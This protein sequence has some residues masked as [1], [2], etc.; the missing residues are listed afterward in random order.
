MMLGGVNRIRL[1]ELIRKELRQMLRDPR[2]KRL[3]FVAPVVQLLVFG[4]AVNTDVRHAATIVMDHDRTADSRELLDA[5]VASGYFR[6]ARWAAR[7]A[8]IVVALDRG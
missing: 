8:E 6:I 3:I 7:P 5:F 2:S 1:R 4:Y